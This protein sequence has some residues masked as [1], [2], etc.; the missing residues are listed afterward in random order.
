M[1]KLS[2]IENFFLII[3]I[4]LSTFYFY[5]GNYF[6]D[7]FLVPVGNYSINFTDLRCVQSWSRLYENY[8]NSFVVYNDIEGCRL[9][10]PKIWI[11]LVKFFF[12][13]EYTSFY[14]IFCFVLYNFIFYYF[15]KKYK[16]IF[17]IYIYFSGVSFLLL[18][19]GNIEILIFIF[20]FFS[21][22]Q[23]NIV[24]LF[25]LFLSIILKVFPIFAL[26]SLLIKKNIKHLIYS[27][28]FLLIYFLFTFEDFKFIFQNTPSTGDIS[29]GTK[30]ITSNVNKYFSININNYILSIFFIFLVFILY[31]SFFKKK[32]INICYVNKEMFLSGGSIFSATFLVSSNHDYRMI[33]IIFL[34][35]LIVNLNLK[36]YK[37]VFFISIILSFEVHRLIYFFGF[38]GGVINSLAKVM[39]F[40]LTSILLL[41]IIKKNIVN[42][43][44]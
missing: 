30:A 4:L 24:K 43:I 21:L 28:V 14:L 16:S 37:Y 6:W 38:Y 23:N 15:L 44:K 8:S 19:R 29:Y 12:K 3:V 27:I 40:L 36:I 2:K 7:F 32:L 17:I 25:L 10:Y 34:I 13:A 35:P 22:I 9:N 33:F 20:L 18:E 42:T 26:L 41:D 39:L 5:A 31:L 11:P 1:Y